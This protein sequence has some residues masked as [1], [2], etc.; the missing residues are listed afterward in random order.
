MQDCSYRTRGG[1]YLTQRWIWHAR[2]LPK[3]PVKIPFEAVL[4]KPPDTL[5]IHIILGRDFFAKSRF[6]A[7]RADIS[8]LDTRVACTIVAKIEY[9]RQTRQ[10]NKSRMIIIGS[11][12]TH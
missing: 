1:P 5:E 8:R 12:R 6:F 2:W 11:L 10:L 7:D 9:I 3:E 4:R